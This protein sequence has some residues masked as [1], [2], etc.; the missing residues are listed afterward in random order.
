MPTLPPERQTHRTKAI[1]LL[2]GSICTRPR[3]AF[4]TDAYRLNIS[5]KRKVDLYE[6]WRTGGDLLAL[7]AVEAL[8]ARVV[9]VP[10]RQIEGRERIP[11]P[12]FDASRYAVPVV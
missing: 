4:V 7:S 10:Q 5:T 1:G 2:I 11:R 3:V 12:D 6:L 9:Y 8:H